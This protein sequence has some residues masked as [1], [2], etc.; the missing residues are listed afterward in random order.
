MT[1]ITTALRILCFTPRAFRPLWSGGRGGRPRRAAVAGLL[2]EA[3]LLWAPVPGRAQALRCDLSLKTTPGASAGPACLDLAA[4]QAGGEALQV[5]ANTTR[6]GLDGLRICKNAFQV[7]VPAGADVVFIYDNSGSMVADYA[8]VDS[9]SGDTAFFH[10]QGCGNNP[11]TTGT[12]TY[13]TQTGPRTVQTVDASVN[14]T[15]IAGDPYNARGRVIARGIDFLAASSPSSAAGAVA[16]A[17]VTAHDRPP[18][19]LSTPGNADLVK[20]SLVLDSIPNTYYGP[21][22]R[23]A[24][25]WLNDATLVRSSRRAIVFISDGGPQDANGINSYLDAVGTIPIFSIFLGAEGTAYARL[26]D[27]SARTEGQFHRVEPGNIAAMDEVMRRI[28]QAITVTDMP[29]RIEVVNTSF[30]PPMTSRSTLL[31]RGADSMVTVTLDSIVALRPGMND[32]T[33]RI[34]LSPTNTREY[35]TRIRADGPLAAASTETLTCHAQPILTLLDAQGRLEGTYPIGA[36]EHEA[37]LLRSASDLARITL[38]ATSRD[39]VRGPQWGDREALVLDL[40]PGPG[41]AVYR[42]RN[43]GIQSS[44]RSP[45]S[46]N[47]VLDA[48]PNGSITLSWTHPR[49]ARERAVLTL[50]GIMEVVTPGTISIRRAVDVAAG[51]PL[52]VPVADPVVLRGGAALGGAPEDP[53]LTHKGVLHNPHGLPDEFLLP[54]R[55]PTFLL[56]TA[57]PFA[58]QVVVFDNLG[59]FLTRTEGRVDSLAWERLRGEADSLTVA[60]SILPVAANGQ[61]FATGAYILKATLSALG[62]RRS[63]PGTPTRVTPVVGA[64]HDMFGYRRN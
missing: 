42:L 51:A 7:A 38:D 43:L 14:C 52:P 63:G 45:V 20:A 9:A 16:F 64:F 31:A 36:S 56:T 50:P 60:L 6:I 62:T 27:I 46:G 13:A 61:Q 44:S 24:N 5:P 41:G 22:L 3:A 29:E 2:F 23:L 33:V 48:S 17:L 47:A 18:L 1:T 32:L 30:E 59:R 8:R 57:A 53:T 25:T 21:P 15:G 39:S 35:K 12:L 55:V 4:L 40:V 34:S 49:D 37:R 19:P 58:Y 54:G 11:R 28:I 10:N 26:E